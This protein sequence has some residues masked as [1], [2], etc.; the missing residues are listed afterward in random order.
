MPDL[1]AI[2]L[3][4]FDKDGTLIDFH[5]M[6]SGWAEALAD[7]LEGVTKRSLRGPLFAMLGYDATNRQAHA[8]GALIATPMVRL[9]DL[10]AGVLI[11]TGLSPAEADTALREA[12]HAP[13]PVTLAHPLTDLPNL[14]AAQRAAGRRSAIATTDDRGPTERTL[15][16]LGIAGAVDAIVCADDGIRPKPAPDMVLYVCTLLGVA[17]VRTAVIGDSPADIAMGRSAGAGL[18]IGVLTG[19]GAAADLADADLIVDSVEAL[20]GTAG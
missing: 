1:T 3:V 13:D 15:V 20:L 9:R 4:V 10:T 11:E 12:W 8:G 17:P 19:I 6:W 14:L 5:A 18:V 2:D 7:G 16:A